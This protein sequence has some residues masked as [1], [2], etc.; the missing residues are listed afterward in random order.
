MSR[1]QP[2][3]CGLRGLRIAVARHVD[4]IE[5]LVLAEGEE[6]ELARAPRRHRNPREARAAGERVDQARLADIGAPGKGDF[7]LAVARQ[8]VDGHHAFDEGAGPFEQGLALGEIGSGEI[9][10]CH[11]HHVR[12]PTPRHA[13]PGAGHPRSSRGDIRG[14]EGRDK[15]GHDEMLQVR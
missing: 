9:G 3:I 4:Q 15:P 8:A 11:R 13:R 2:L 12:Q 1:V 5:D 7:G 6:V 10:V 14:V